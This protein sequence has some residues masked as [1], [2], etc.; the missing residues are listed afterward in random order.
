M[1][2]DSASISWVSVCKISH[3]LLEVLIF[4]SVTETLA[5]IRQ[6]F[7]EESMSH[8]GCLKG[9]LGSG[10]VEKGEIGEEQSHVHAN[11]FLHQGN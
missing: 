11:H 9:I 4:L 2:G 7:G 5:T 8:T 6:V 3:S 10:Q 1:I